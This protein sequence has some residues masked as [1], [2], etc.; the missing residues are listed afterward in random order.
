MKNNFGVPLIK[1]WSF[2]LFAKTKPFVFSCWDRK[3]KIPYNRPIV[4]EVENIQIGMG[5]ISSEYSKY[6]KERKAKYEK[7]EPVISNGD[8]E[9]PSDPEDGN[10]PPF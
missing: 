8:D 3:S 5:Y 1:L 7:K 6:K 2:E 10:A 4:E 9:E